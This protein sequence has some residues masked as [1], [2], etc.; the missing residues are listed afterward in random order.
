MMRVDARHSPF[1][2]W[3]DHAAIRELVRGALALSAGERLIL[4][5]GLIPGL[6]DDIGDAAFEDF[7]DEVRVKARRYAE[8]MA[9]PGEGGASRRTV[10]EPLGGATIHGEAHLPGTRDPRRPGGRALERQW[11]TDFWN[12]IGP[13]GT[14]NDGGRP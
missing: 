12:E 2:A 6:I 3:L 5:K 11:E 4:I 14:N 10:G 13:A 9:H 1:Y 8:A 7:L